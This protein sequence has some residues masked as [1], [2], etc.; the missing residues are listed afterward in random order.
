MDIQVRLTP[1]NVYELSATGF[2]RR[3]E[4][5]ERFTPIDQKPLNFSQ[6][7]TSLELLGK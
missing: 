1:P 5:W 6:N 2:W 4:L 3:Y 7:P